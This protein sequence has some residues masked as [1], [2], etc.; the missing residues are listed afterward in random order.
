M[1]WPIPVGAIIQ[2]FDVA[3]SPRAAMYGMG[4]S[5][6]AT[7]LVLWVYARRVDRLV[8]P[9]IDDPC[10]VCGWDVDRATSP[11]P[12]L[13]DDLTPGQ[14][15]RAYLRAW[16]SICGM[17]FCIQV[18][19][20]IIHPGVDVDMMAGVT[21]CVVLFALFIAPL[22]AK[23]HSR[24]AVERAGA[25]GIVRANARIAGELKL[26]LLVATAISLAFSGP[27]AA[28]PL[29]VLFIWSLVAL[30]VACH[31]LDKLTSAVSPPRRRLPR[32]PECGHDVTPVD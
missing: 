24:A 19:V 10:A 11:A 25:A 18:V 2:L 27:E 22:D 4:L 9:L 23:L 5:L 6:A 28:A 13:Q 32:C 26:L 12:V 3:L 29:M 7:V 20:W 31:R 15:A 30:L 1:F 16:A 14:K 8:R 21:L 17:A